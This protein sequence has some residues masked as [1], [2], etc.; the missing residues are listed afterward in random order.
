MEHRLSIN[1]EIWRRASGRACL[2][3]ALGVVLTL[4]DTAIAT[5][6]LGRSGR[7]PRVARQLA[8]RL[9]VRII[10]F[11]SSSTEGV[12]A[13]SRSATYP[14]RLETELNQAL[15]GEGK[16]VSVLNRGVGGEDVDDM[17]ARLDR[18]VLREKPDL[19]IWQTGSNDPLR[20]VPLEHFVEE[21]KAGISKMR[22]AGL[23]VMLMEPQWCPKL[24]GTPGA[25]LYRE[26]VRSVGAELGVRVIRRADLMRKWVD[27][28]RL[29]SSQLLSGDG[30]H[31]TDGG[32]ALLAREIAN[33]ILSA[34]EQNPDRA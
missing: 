1:R 9:P 14:A 26:A 10:A 32:Y 29:S 21:T 3:I 8:S 4:S 34:V 24:Q 6:G 20:S 5:Q 33:E 13:T 16:R 28:K 15:P 23:D 18:D 19:V 2:S 22:A 27:E 25:D 31:M 7:L 17:L 12:G 11:G 30:F